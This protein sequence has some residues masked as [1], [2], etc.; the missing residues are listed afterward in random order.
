[1]VRCTRNRGSWLVVVV[2]LIAGVAA[3]TPAT[4]RADVTSAEVNRALEE[5]VIAIKQRCRADGSWPEYRRYTGGYTCLASLALLEAGESPKSPL[6]AAALERVRAVPNERTYVVGLKLMAL[7]AAADPDRYR[8]EIDAAADWLLLTRCPSGL[9]SYGASA[10]NCNFDHSNTQFALLGLHAAAEAGAEIPRGVWRDIRKAVLDTQQSDGGWSYRARG[11]SFGAA[12]AANVTNLHIVGERAAAR[13]GR[14]YSNGVVTHCGEYRYSRPMAE[15]MEWLSRA[16]RAD[17]H[18]GGD[19]NWVYYWLLAVE[20]T[21]IFSGERY[22]GGHDWYREGAAYLVSHQRADGTWTGDFHNTCF[23]VMFLAK[24]RKPLLVQKLKWSDD[25]QWNLDRYDVAG[26]VGFVGDRFGKATASQSIP[27]EAPLS[28]WLE[29]PLLYVEGHQFPKWSA[30]QREKLREYVEQGGTIF[31]DAC[32][33]RRAF[34]QG[35]EQFASATF[36]EYPLR[37]LGPAHPVYH[38]EFDLEPAE[39]RGIDVGCRTAVFFSPAN[40]GALWEMTT[41]PALSEKALQLGANIAAHALGRRPLRDRLDALV[42]PE[43]DQPDDPGTPPGDALRLTQI[44]YDG[45]WRPYPLAPVGLAEFLRDEL[46][47]DVVSRYRQLRLTSEELAT[48]PILYMTGC[49][50][51]TLSPEERVR[52]WPAISGGAGFLMADACCGWESF[53]EAFRAMIAETFP[54]AQLARLPVDHAIIQ[55]RPGFDV[56]HVRYNAA[57]LSEQ[58]GLDMPELWGLTLDGRLALVYS[59]YAYLCGTSAQAAFGCRGLEPTDAQRLAANIVL[60]ALTH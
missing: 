56:S 17:H 54:N 27:F 36:P 37:E 16:F 15:G 28:E 40:I 57:A 38:L 43:A 41:K 1:M 6:L 32:C 5:G 31:F 49:S 23:A 55:G 24:G 46:K 18:P 59:P 8:A 39:L 52:H 14:N 45:D 4:G 7:A 9:W 25:Q 51:F 48:S 10:A 30:R 12:T 34:V 20:R 44:V 35:F 47:L 3:G 58:P 50:G 21:G 29:A 42:M 22:F 11:S 26:L 33:R 2:G 53:D 60:Y 13:M 19:D